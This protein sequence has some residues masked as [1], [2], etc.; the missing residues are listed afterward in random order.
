MSNEITTQQA[1]QNA[2]Q[3]NCFA[4]VKAFED[5]QRMGKM[6]SQSTLIPKDYQNNVPNCV[7]ALEMASRMGASPLM[8]M[9]NLYI[10]HGKPGWSSQ[11]VI[12][13]VNTCGR[14]KPLRF[15]FTGKENTD[16]WSC[17]AWTV[18]KSVDIPSN[19]RTLAD[20]VAANLP[21]LKSPKVSIDMAK[22]EGWYQKN[23]SK[24]QTIPELMLHYR[25]GSFFGKL[26]APEILMGLQSAEEVMDMI[27]VTPPHNNN[28][29]L[30]NAF[31][32]NGA[33]AAENA[34]Q[35]K[36]DEILSSTAPKAPNPPKDVSVDS[37]TGE[38]DDDFDRAEKEKALSIID[39][40]NKAPTEA[41][42]KYIMNLNIDHIA[43]MTPEWQQK[44]DAV[45]A[46]CNQKL[47]VK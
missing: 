30:K 25:S 14:F 38:I 24:W 21:V 26:Y 6:I 13:A 19:I 46:Q 34:P 7:I 27:D 18:E 22:K 28:T 32:E 10:V 31:M 12:G 33:A 45:L 39:D 47:G 29:D 44:I 2:M 41:K 5:A 35:N 36:M 17:V 20:A 43:A 16:E 4:T 15:D 37:V 8:I 42:L 1:Q 40:L 23:G 9:Q 3:L 11:F